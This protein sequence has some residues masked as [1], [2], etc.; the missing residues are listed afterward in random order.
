MNAYERKKAFLRSIVEEHTQILLM[1]IVFHT[2]WKCFGQEWSSQ[3]KST[4]QIGM[5]D[6][7]NIQASI[8][9]RKTLRDV[10]YGVLEFL[11]AVLNDVTA[12]SSETVWD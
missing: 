11:L 5:K 9:L 10:S 3:I 1:L 4:I 2:I 6:C 8:S 12:F 7:C